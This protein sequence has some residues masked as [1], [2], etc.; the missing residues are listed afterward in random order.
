[1][2][3]LGGSSLD[4]S[5]AS[6][7]DLTNGVTGSGAVVL[8][9]APTLNA[10]ILNTIFFADQYAGA[11]ASIKINAAITAAIAAGGGTVDARGLGGAQTISA[12]INVGNAGF[13]PVAVLL[14]AAGTWTCTIADGT[15]SAI[16]LFD[17]STFRGYGPGGT[18]GLIIRA[19]STANIA[20]VLSIDQSNAP[21][22]VYVDFGGFI[23]GAQAG[24]T[25]GIAYLECSNLDD[26]STISNI[27]VSMLTSGVGI[28]EHGMCCAASFTNVTVNANNTTG[29]LPW[30]VGKAN[31]NHFLV[32]H[33]N[34]SID[35]PGAGHNHLQ[36][37][38]GGFLGVTN[39]YGVYLETG[40]SDGTTPL[41]YIPSGIS[42]Q[43]NFFGVRASFGVGGATQYCFDV[44]SPV[45]V[46]GLR[47]F[48]NSD[49]NA[50]NDHL[51]GRTIFG[52]SNGNVGNYSTYSAQ[53]TIALSPNAGV[54][55]AANAMLAIFP[56]SSNRGIVI[57]NN[58]DALLNALDI[59]SGST[60]AQSSNIRFFDR[61]SSEWGISKDAGNIFLLQDLANAKSRLVFTQDSAAPV[62]GVLRLLDDDTITWRNFANG[63]DLAIAHD[64]SDNLDV[65][66]FTAVNAVKYLVSGSQ[67]AAANLSNGTTGS[68]AIVLASSPV[69][70]TPNIGAAIAASLQPS[71]D[72]ITAIQIFKA[73]GSTRVLDVDTTNSRIGI[74]LVNP[75][76]SLNIVTAN[77]TNSAFNQFLVQS[78]DSMAIDLGGSIG[79]GGASTGTTLTQWATIAGR[80]ENSTDANV[81]SYLAF[82]TRPAGGSTTERMRI[83][84]TGG[85][86]VGATADPGVGVINANIGF[87]V[88]GGATSTHVLRGN[89]TNFV[90]AALA[91]ADLSNGVTGSG[92]VV[93][94]GSPAI[95][96]P[97]LQGVDGTTSYIVADVNGLTSGYGAFLHFTDGGHTYN[98]GLG[99]D[100]NTDFSLYS[101]RSPGSA[102]T[103]RLRIAIGAPTVGHVLRSDGAKFVDAA[104]A[105]ADLSNGVTGSGAIVLTTSPAISTAT[106]T[107]PTGGL[108]LSS[109]QFTSTGAST[110][111]IP[112]GVTA[113]KVTVYGAGGAGGGGVVNGAGAGGGGGGAA[114]K[115]LSG[116]TP[117]NTLTTSVGTGGTGVAA[118]GGNNGSDS[119]VSSGTQ[120]IS[121]ITGKAGAG[122]TVGNAVNGAPGGTGSLSTGGDLNSAGNPGHTAYPG[123]CFSGPGG[124]GFL[125]GGGG[126]VGS[127]T[128]GSGSSQGAG[129]G[130]GGSSLNATGGAGANGLILF[131]WVA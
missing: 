31:E 101:G 20:S 30:L 4:N 11:D 125:G 124:N 68:G 44:S 78:S 32:N 117:G 118:S 16:K 89:G 107:G 100:P 26:C 3:I 38:G 65:T 69:L 45:N 93:L 76:S 128:G 64:D 126:A 23:L 18:N 122:G 85:L 83:S 120:T 12:Q 10:K 131:E 40:A 113:V 61:S 94:A 96:T 55:T 28:W 8:A 130:G 86:N 92:A 99:S 91:A 108:I 123:N 34:I 112:T 29:A 2:I 46:Q 67:I 127:G 49:L 84:S 119:S 42:G 41:V 98:W 95:T 21:A 62:S 27:L 37:Q 60:T 102:G 22:G 59:Y 88:A 105:A 77:T 87:K 7:A 51:T 53:T 104:L 72:S 111:T 57:Q 56:S 36:F 47:V 80:K 74:G 39:W 70:T 81:A 116:L 66:A 1:M 50:I 48:G 121:T 90:D 73:N 58:A 5:V 33:Y 75:N 115:W 82:S 25:I 24:A 63:A 15:S 106:M 79:F 97:S 129:G 114:I 9:T 17:K 110:F 109:Q 19:A 54:P 43:Q 103:Q 14:P 71:S 13:V 35:H 52:D 6:A